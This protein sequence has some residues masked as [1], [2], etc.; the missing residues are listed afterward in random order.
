MQIGRLY[1]A[2]KVRL[3]LSVV[4]CG[5][6]HGSRSRSQRAWPR[7][8][9]LLPPVQHFTVNFVNMVSLKVYLQVVPFI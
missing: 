8:Q 6:G 3:W 5:A 4:T 2:V 9:Y 7:T 1:K